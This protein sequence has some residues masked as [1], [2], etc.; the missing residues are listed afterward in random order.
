M[1]TKIYTRLF[2]VLFLFVLA[3]SQAFAVKHVISVGNYYF[4]PSSLSNVNL[5]DTIHWNWVNGSHTTT[6]SSIPAGAASWDHPLNSSSTSFEYIPTVSGT[7]NYVCTPHAGMGMVGSFT[8]AAAQ[9]LAVTATATP[10]QVCQGG[11]SQL[12]AVATGGTGS[13]TY[14]WTSIPAG[15]TSSLKNP[16]VVPAQNTTYIVNVTS[17]TQS[18]S[19]N[20]NVAVQL[21]PSAFAGTDTTMCLPAAQIQ[22]HGTAS[23]YAAVTWSSSGDG[24]FQNIHSLN[25]SYTPGATDLLGGTISFTLTAS[26]VSPCAS[27]ASDTKDVVL[28]NC[29]G[30]NDGKGSPANLSVY[31]N[32]TSGMITI[33]AS[34]VSSAASVRITDMQGR[35]LV[36]E[37][38]DAKSGSIDK[39]YDLSGFPKGVYFVGVNGDNS[40]A[41]KKILVR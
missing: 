30:I 17:G 40:S 25:A 38:V 4:N 2:A 16:V 22:L 21:P 31:P 24:T 28:Q 37:Q 14:S 10:G 8:V 9:P 3:G 33:K 36:S 35:V 12:N 6:S 5:G 11:S 23:S 41:G 20:A 15:F 39:T 7:Y 29:T 1:K 19:S 27:A 18:E 13:Y 32:P 34:S 26:A